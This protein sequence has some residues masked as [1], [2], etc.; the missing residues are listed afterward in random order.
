[1][2]KMAAVVLSAL[3]GH[4]KVLTELCLVGIGQILKLFLGGDAGRILCVL[5][6]MEQ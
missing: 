1:M 4:F 5:L 2:S 6:V 3:T